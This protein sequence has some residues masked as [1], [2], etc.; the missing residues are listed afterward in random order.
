MVHAVRIV[1]RGGWS[2]EG[3]PDCG[4]GEMSVTNRFER[5]SVSAVLWWCLDCCF[6]C[7]LSVVDRRCVVRLLDGVG[8]VCVL[9]A[10]SV[11]SSL[12]R[13]PLR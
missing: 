1:V 10:R 4:V 9:L 8:S 5:P 3:S 13:V 11:N 12:H 7:L 6:L 2:C